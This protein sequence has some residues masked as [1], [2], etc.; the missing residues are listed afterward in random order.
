MYSNESFVHSLFCMTCKY[1]TL[2]LYHHL[3][4]YS[5]D[6]PVQLKPTCCI[7]LLQLTVR[8]PHQSSPHMYTHMCALQTTHTHTHIHTH[9][10]VILHT[11]HTHCALTHSYTLL[12]QPSENVPYTSTFLFWYFNMEEMIKRSNRIKVLQCALWPEVVTLMHTAP[13]E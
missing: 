2:L 11:T 6:L 9:T 10:H 13:G 1:L 7:L 12:V 8:I 4:C 3:Q 5:L